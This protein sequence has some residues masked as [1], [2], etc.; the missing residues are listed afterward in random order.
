MNLFVAVLLAS[1]LHLSG[2]TG[3]TSLLGSLAWTFA[4]I[5]LWLAFFNMLPFYPMDGGRIL[6]C[7]FPDRMRA[8][9]DRHERASAFAA[10]ALI[11]VLPVGCQLAG[12]SLHVGELM[13]KGS[14]LLTGAPHDAWY[15]PMSA[16]ILS[17]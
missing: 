6:S 8:W 14:T 17:K 16:W 10:I 11:I 3:D 5:N 9:L 13:E 1:A 12:Y 4:V 7:A 2:V 15:H